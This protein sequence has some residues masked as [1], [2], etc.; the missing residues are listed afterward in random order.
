[1]TIKKCKNNRNGK[2]SVAVYLTSWFQG[3]WFQRNQPILP[4]EIPVCFQ[5]NFDEAILNSTEMKK[6]SGFSRR[7]LVSRY[8]TTYNSIT[9]ICTYVNKETREKYKNTVIGNEE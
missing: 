9:L 8:T 4:N 5:D 2:E 6:L 1:M 7:K 3:T